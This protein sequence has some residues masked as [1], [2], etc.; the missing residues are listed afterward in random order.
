MAV[1]IRMRRIGKNPKK[2]PHFRIT[3]FEETRNRDGRL[4]EE[5]GYYTPV[6]GVVKLDKERY[7]HWIKMG[8]QP[9]DTIKSIVK[10]QK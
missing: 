2:Q 7:A 1:R 3:V 4:I 8:A 5:L 10:K 9:T 6:T